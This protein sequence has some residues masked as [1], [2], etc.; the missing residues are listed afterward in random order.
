MQI[1]VLYTFDDSQTPFLLRS[2]A[3]F[4]VRM[5]EIAGGD[6]E[7]MTVG[8]ID[9]K[10]CAQQI[11]DGSPDNFKLDVCD[12]AV[13]YKDITEQPYEPFVGHGNL[14]HYLLGTTLKMVAG[15][16]CQNLSASV[17]FGGDRASLWTLEVRLKLNTIDKAPSRTQSARPL[18]ELAPVKRPRVSQTPLVPSLATRTRS[19]PSFSPTPALYSVMSADKQSRSRYDQHLVK[20]RFRLTPFVTTPQPLAAPRGKSGRALRTRLMMTGCPPQSLPIQEELD[21]SDDSEYRDSTA[22]DDGETPRHFQALP[23]PE[24]WDQKRCHLV[25]GTSLPHNHGLVCINNNCSTDLSPTWR[26]FETGEYHQ[27]YHELSRDEG[28]FNKD[29]YE[30]MYGPLCNACYLFLRS[31]GFMRPEIVVRKYLQLKRYKGKVD[32]ESLLAVATRKANILALLLPVRLTFIKPKTPHED[33]TVGPLTDIDMPLDAGFTPPVMAEKFNTTVINIEDDKENLPPLGHVDD[34]EEF[35]AMLAKSLEETKNGEPTTDWMDLFGEGLTPLD[36]LMPSLP[37][38]DK[39]S[40]LATRTDTVMSWNQ[41]Q[42]S[43]PNTETYDEEK[44]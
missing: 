12:Y 21:G 16:V 33:N 10:T 35:E 9:L 1:K 5:A 30:G 19:L 38:A 3:Q 32:K 2:N 36:N 23:E 4:P 20:D 24:A 34:L 14:S 26:Y 6:G 17:L 11:V 13:Y 41:M 7:A 28:K 39:S 42:R 25:L 29:L 40:P 43:T 18:V 8:G 15:R 37:V 44:S 27:N 22:I 31:K